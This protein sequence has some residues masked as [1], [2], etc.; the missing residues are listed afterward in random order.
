MYSSIFEFFTNLINV[1]GQASNFLT[2]G[3]PGTDFNVLGLIT[4]GGL[5]FLLGLKV[6]HLLNPLA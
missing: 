2:W 1:M 6:Y 5:V 3:I 4:V